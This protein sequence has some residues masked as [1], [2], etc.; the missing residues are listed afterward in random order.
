MVQTAVETTRYPTHRVP[1]EQHDNDT[2]HLE[3]NVSEIALLLPV[4]LAFRTNEPKEGSTTAEDMRAQNTTLVDPITA[5]TI[6]GGSCVEVGRVCRHC[7][8]HSVKG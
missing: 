7:S 3:T 4:D 5:G 8:S 1:R 6:G 2:T